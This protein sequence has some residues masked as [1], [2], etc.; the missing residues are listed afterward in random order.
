MKVQK[1][2][3]L[4]IAFLMLY[5]I[6]CKKADNDGNKVVIQTE[7]L[8][9]IQ[10][11]IDV[12]TQFLVTGIEAFSEASSTI[13][14]VVTNVEKYFI[15]TLWDIIMNQLNVLEEGLTENKKVVIKCIQ[16]QGPNIT[17]TVLNFTY[18][19]STW[20]LNAMKASANLFKAL[21]GS[22]QNM[23]NQMKNLTKDMDECV[24]A[25]DVEACSDEIF[26]TASTLM[27]FLWSIFEIEMDATKNFIGNITIAKDR[28]QQD[29]AQEFES[30]ITSVSSAISNCIQEKTENGRF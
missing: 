20:E 21:V 14:N 9:I 24:N 25:E 5:Q 26:R 1:T 28:K 4:F 27:K 22:V 13:I 10:A 17:D 23:N 15:E 29:A 3:F 12:V 19:W 8:K 6:D 16:L 30:R 18:E 7:G 11:F 2:A